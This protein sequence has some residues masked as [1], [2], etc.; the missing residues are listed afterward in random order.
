MSDQS[1]PFR[2]S[3]TPNRI[4][5]RTW[6][7][8]AGAGGLTA[9]AGCSSSDD[10]ES[11]QGGS[12][13][14]GTAQSTSASGDGDLSNTTATYWN[15][16]NVQSES[17]KS[18]S[19]NIVDT[20]QSNT[21]ASIKTNFSTV[22]DL[23]GAKWK[24]SFRSGNYPVIF[25]SVVG[26]AG[27]F[28]QN[29]YVLP[30]SEYKDKLDQDVLE[31]I[32]WLTDKLEYTYR[33][34]RKDL[35][36]IPYGLNVQTG[37]VGRMD[38][39]EEAGLSP[40]DDFPPDDFEHLVEVAQTL[41]KDGPAKHGF[42]SFGQS[43]DSFDEHI[44]AWSVA[45][46]GKKGVYLNED[47][48]KG[49]LTN[50]SWMTAGRNYIE[51]YTEHDLGPTDTPSISTEKYLTRLANGR[52]SMSSSGF[53]NLPLLKKRAPDLVKNGT[54]KWA[55]NWKGE[56][57]SRGCTAPYTLALTRKP[58]T[59]NKDTWEKRQQVGVELMNQ[60]LSKEV[61]RKMFTQFGLFPVRKDVWSDLPIGERPD[62][63]LSSFKTM[64]EEGGPAWSA[65]PVSLELIINIAPPHIQSALKG[66]ISPEQA[67]RNI[68]KDTNARL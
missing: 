21:G 27:P 8:V 36:E 3:G 41:Q 49:R 51:T 10:Q 33:G 45:D 55:P 15:T 1:D 52:A 29:G 38:H 5:R 56:S 18:A 24:T 26:W 58:E 37:M 19:K 2:T 6:L 25:D 23:I 48:T 32:Q 17:A 7:K 31:N 63:Y 50:D 67:M 12:E 13:Q 64:A 57:G 60:F 46:G 14:Q 40:E 20:V 66:Q 35:Y 65:H 61:Q 62:N 54:I 34:Y 16:I 39:F 43:S 47:W 68:Q 53:L 9:L 44:L 30:F 11:E 59:A 28:M 22:S 4:S 42:S